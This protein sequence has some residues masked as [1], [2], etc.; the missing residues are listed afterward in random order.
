M[1]V[2]KY[3]L[4]F[5]EVVT[6]FLMIGVI[7]L[8]RSRDHGGGLAFGAGVGESLF[9]AQAGNVLTRVTVVLAIIFLVNTTI[10]TLMGTSSQKETSVVGSVPVRMP[11][12]S[13]QQA[14]PVQPV[15]PLPDSAVPPS[16]APV[17]GSGF[18]TVEP[19]L[20]E[21]GGEIKPVDVGTPAQAG[22]EPQVPQSEVPE[23]GNKTVE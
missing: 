15:Q 18:G 10:L 14:R 20:P 9:G 13:P 3:F 2:L 4:V 6:C 22:S 1:I 12:S 23:A 16:E 5:V 17:S 19:V 7:L 8:Q 11:A 21:M